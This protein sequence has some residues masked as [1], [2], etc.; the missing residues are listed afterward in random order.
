VS[1]GAPGPR[2]YPK[3]GDFARC[4]PV[5]LRAE[6]GY[7]NHPADPGGATNKGITQRTYDTWRTR[8]GQEPAAVKTITDDEVRD[9]YD[10]QYWR[11]SG[12]HQLAWPLCLVH[13]DAAVNHGV[14]AAAKFLARAQGSHEVYLKDRRAFYHELV[15]RKPP[16]AVFLK[17]WLN[18][19]AHLEDV[20]RKAAPT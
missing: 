12:A 20:I 3:A 14:G 5:I 15:R 16:M 9:I 8:Y 6:G 7:V 11:A 13:F 18:R 1:P 10:Q 4:L 17:G 19:I 2:P